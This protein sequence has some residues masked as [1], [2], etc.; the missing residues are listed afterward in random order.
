MDKIYHLTSNKLTKN[1]I[2]N[3]T[4]YF[5]INNMFDDII[6]KN[7]IP[8]SVI[9]ILFGDSYNHP[10]Y[11]NSFP[12]NLKI[13]IFGN[14]FNQAICSKMLPDSIEYIK[15]GRFFNNFIS[16]GALPKSLTTL[17]F[18][19]HYNQHINVGILPEN[20]K[21]LYLGIAYESKIMPNA[22]PESLEILMF[23]PIN[24]QLLR[25]L[26]KNITKIF[27]KSCPWTELIYIDNVE[28]YYQQFILDAALISGVI[29]I[30]KPIHIFSFDKIDIS[31]Y[32]DRY[33]FSEYRA[34][35]RYD[36]ILHCITIVNTKDNSSDKN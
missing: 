29:D 5:I 8:V 18:G 10:I 9:T 13:I 12:I 23:S 33:L 25:D 32:D 4:T 17:I 14:N 27:L 3:G 36:Y 30:P 28:I 19:D 11:P 15:F 20:L 35:F 22:L 7:C 2:P 24:S 34:E 21:N 6:R 26:P 1:M 16:V 31:K